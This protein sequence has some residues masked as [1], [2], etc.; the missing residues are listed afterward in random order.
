[1][2]MSTPILISAR[3]CT[4]LPPIRSTGITNSSSK[5]CWEVPP[6]GDDKCGCP[7]L[8][9]QCCCTQHTSR[10]ARSR[11]S[12]ASWPPPQRTSR[13]GRRCSLCP[14]SRVLAYLRGWDSRQCLLGT[15]T[16]G[17]SLDGIEEVDVAE[18]QVP[19]SWVGRQVEA[20]IVQV[21]YHGRFETP[22]PLTAWTL[23][24]TLDQVN[25]L[26]IVATLRDSEASSP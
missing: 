21:L 26:D 11:E 18:A 8:W 13:K 9:C 25:D 7:T 6:R 12:P 16:A 2:C 17:H 22:E 1:M 19:Y 24:G 20:M 23:T 5:L 3:I 4:P 10:R 15:P 14:R